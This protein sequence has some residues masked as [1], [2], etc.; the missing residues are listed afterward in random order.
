MLFGKKGGEERMAKGCRTEM[1]SPVRGGWGEALCRTWNG[2]PELK[3]LRERQ[4]IAPNA[5]KT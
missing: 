5:K 2:W 4:L 1:K 3:M